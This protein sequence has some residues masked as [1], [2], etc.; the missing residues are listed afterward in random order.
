MQGMKFDVRRHL[1]AGAIE[2]W[3]S[4][5]W[6]GKVH[7]FNL[8][9]WAQAQDHQMTVAEVDEFIANGGKVDAQSY[10]A[11]DAVKAF[12]EREFDNRITVAALLRYLVARERD[13]KPKATVEDINVFI[14]DRADYQ[15]Q[16]ASILAW[17]ADPEDVNPQVCTDED[18][19]GEKTPTP[20]QFHHLPTRNEKDEV[21]TLT[22]RNSDEP[23]QVGQYVVDEAEGKILFVCHDCQSRLNRLAGSQNR[24]IT[25]YTRGGAERKLGAIE[26]GQE[27]K[28]RDAEK[29]A[30]YSGRPRFDRG[31]WN[32]SY[33]GQPRRGG[34]GDRRNDR[35][36]DD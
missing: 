23:I 26:R 29:V 11:E 33:A 8:S 22:H 34:R 9:L 21:V 17:R 5:R 15:S 18:H 31:A 16:R 24:K 1:D 25:W 30:R 27:K 28:R 13:S 35:R 19:V 10:M 3:E 7:A 4:G 36:R 20:S 6:K 14:A 32:D 2:A 12:N